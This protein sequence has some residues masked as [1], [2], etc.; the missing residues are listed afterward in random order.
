V[1]ARSRYLRFSK[2]PITSSH[3]PVLARGHVNVHIR[4]EARCCLCC[5]AHAPNPCPEL[6]RHDTAC[7][8]IGHEPTAVAS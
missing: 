7:P 4:P 1:N 3:A 5:S 6:N 2:K 8:V